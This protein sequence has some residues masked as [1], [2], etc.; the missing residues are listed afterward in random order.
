MEK[1]PRTEDLEGGEM[2]VQMVFVYRLLRL[3]DAGSVLTS[4]PNGPAWI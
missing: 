3:Q 2:T 4:A 1:D